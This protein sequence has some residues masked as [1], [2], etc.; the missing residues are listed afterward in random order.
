MSRSRKLL[1]LA[2]LLASL[3]LASTAQAAAPRLLSVDQ[4][5]RHPA[6]GF[7]APGADDVTVYLST[8]A[9]RATDGG[10]LVENVKEIDF[11]TAAEIANGAWLDEYQVDAGTYYVMLNANTYDSEC[12]TCTNGYSNMLTLTIP[13]DPVAPT[14]PAD[15]CFDGIDNDG[16]GAV[17]LADLDYYPNPADSTKECDQIRPTPAGKPTP[18]RKVTPTLS[19]SRAK[20][21]AKVILKRK[22]K[23]NY[24]HGAGKYLKGTKRLSRTKV[25]YNR[26][27]WYAGDAYWVGRVTIWNSGVERSADWN[28]AY[29]IK[30][31]DDYCKSVLHKKHC[32]RTYRA[33]SPAR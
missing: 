18:A 27:G 16:D 2:T 12:S 1:L 22:F 3:S 4:Q 31:T 30:R 32:T 7:S 19:V 9:A 24:T 15:Q 29:T 5:N 33:R 14:P 6:V 11:L 17:D 10:F 8:S 13:A 21:W 26:V 23:G 20:H 28:Y 25:R